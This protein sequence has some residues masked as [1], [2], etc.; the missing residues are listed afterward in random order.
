MIE[1]LYRGSPNLPICSKFPDTESSENGE[2]N[3]QQ[4]GKSVANERDFKSPNLQQIDGKSPNQLQ[5]MQQIGEIG[6]IA[7]SVA[8]VKNL[9][10]MSEIHAYHEF[11]KFQK[12]SPHL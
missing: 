1:M 12:K 10:Q 9:Q 5:I 3:L 8:N 4:I 7:E 11:S 6:E 2:I